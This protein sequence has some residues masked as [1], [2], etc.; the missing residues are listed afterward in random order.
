MK[1]LKDYIL[2]ET[3]LKEGMPEKYWVSYNWTADGL[4]ILVLE[5]TTGITDVEGHLMT[6][7]KL[8]VYN[9]LDRVTRESIDRQVNYK[10]LVDSYNYKQKAKYEYEEGV[11][12]NNVLEFEVFTYIQYIED[13]I[14]E[15]NK[16][17]N[18]VF[19]NGL[20]AFSRNSDYTGE[21]KKFIS[22]YYQEWKD[23]Y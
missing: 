6:Q 13:K 2:T 23:K 1:T 21:N 15:K 10:F 17:F 14:R 7:L 22:T 18:F 3:K 4:L 16:N 8:F 19:R 5:D 11:G 20:S 12:S 9:I